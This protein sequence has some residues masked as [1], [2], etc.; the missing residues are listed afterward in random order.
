MCVILRLRPPAIG[1][2]KGKLVLGAL[3]GLGVQQS[4][5]LGYQQK[6]KMFFSFRL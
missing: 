5:R 3:H 1:S 2:L 6:F 4:Q